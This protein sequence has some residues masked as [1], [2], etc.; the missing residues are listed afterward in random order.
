[1]QGHL[2]QMGHNEEFWQ[3]VVHWR[4]KWQITSVFLPQEPHEWYERQKDMTPEHEPPRLEGVQYAP[5]EE[6]RTITISSKK[7][8]VAG[9]KQKWHSVVDVSGGESKIWRGKE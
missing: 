9:P 4:E 6:Q 5:R 8:E 1:M 7:S 3:N 2:R